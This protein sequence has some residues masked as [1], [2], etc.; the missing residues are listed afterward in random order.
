[1]AVG[2]V[3]VA[4]GGFSSLVQVAGVPVY[5]A[6]VALAVNLAV[7]AV[8]TPLLDLR[9]VPRGLDETVVLRP[10]RPPVSSP[11]RTL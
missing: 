6:L 7:T 8:L 2:T 11:G 1:M 9:D 5:A 3:L 4:T 10:R